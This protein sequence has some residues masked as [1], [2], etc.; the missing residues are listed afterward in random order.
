[1]QIAGRLTV[2][3]GTAVAPGSSGQLLTD[4]EVGC[5]VYILKIC[6][7]SWHMK[8]RNMVQSC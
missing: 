7:A 3:C 1:M 8:M 6:R 5:E 2:S 4:F